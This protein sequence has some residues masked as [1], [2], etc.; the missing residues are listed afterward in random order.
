MQYWVDY[1]T[2]MHES[3]FWKRQAHRFIGDHDPA[4]G[5]QILDIAE[6]QGETGIE[7]N[8]LLDDHG[9]EAIPRGS[10]SWSSLTLTARAHRRQAQRRDNAN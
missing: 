5:Q 3:S 2:G 10:S 7:P 4:L 1:I 8:G 6:A 9:R